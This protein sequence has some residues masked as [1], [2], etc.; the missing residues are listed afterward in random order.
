MERNK[1]NKNEGEGLRMDKLTE[2]RLDLS[3]VP[4]LLKGYLKQAI[5]DDDTGLKKEIYCEVLNFL[6]DQIHNIEAKYN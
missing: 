5:E 4:F 2:R 1:M 6:N 3:G